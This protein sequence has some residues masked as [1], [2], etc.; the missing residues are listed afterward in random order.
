MIGQPAQTL[1]DLADGHVRLL[2]L[3]RQKHSHVRSPVTQL[4]RPEDHLV[5]EGATAD[6]EALVREAGL[7]LP[8]GGSR[9]AMTGEQ[10]GEM[11]AIEAVVTGGSSM[12]GWTP[13]QLRLS[14]RFAVEILGVKRHGSNVTAPL[15]KF[16]FAAGDVVVVRAGKDRLTEA[17]DELGLLAISSSPVE[18]GTA[19]NWVVPVVVLAAALILM[20]MQVV[21]VAVA[22]FGAAVVIVA[23]RVL[24]LHQAYEALD[25]PVLV[26]LA[27]I[28][29][30]SEA[31]RSTGVT[32]L[33][34]QWLSAHATGLSPIW[35]LA[36]IMGVAMLI[37]PFL[38]NAATVLVAAPIAAGFAKNLGYDPDPFLMAVALGAASDF[39]TPVGHQ[40][41]LLVYGAGGYRFMDYPRLGAPLSLLVLAAGVPLIAWVWP[42]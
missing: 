19:R 25:A 3:I 41:N 5:I 37:T 34:S 28:I 13:A 8:K 14:E 12:L 40:C 2:T 7:S 42:P 11:Q 26:T 35:A 17:L 15:A 10:S 18:I 22:F 31:L 20:V 33:L 36:L 24:P 23:L 27:C 21:P 6:V 32:D 16:R 29:P 9:L 4:L 39:L 38:N 30:L 1:I